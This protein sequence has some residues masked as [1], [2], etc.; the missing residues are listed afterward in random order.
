MCSAL[1]PIHQATWDHPGNHLASLRTRGLAMPF[2]DILLA[3]VA[4]DHDAEL[5]PY[6]AHLRAIQGVLTNLRLF[7]GPLT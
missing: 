1:L 5:W 3:A 6:D 4:I 2:Q 7:D